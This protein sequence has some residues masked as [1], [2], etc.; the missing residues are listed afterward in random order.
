M[1]GGIHTAVEGVDPG[2]PGQATSTEG[3]HPPFFSSP[4]LTHSSSCLFLPS[5]SVAALCVSPLSFPYRWKTAFISQ[6]EA[7]RIIWEKCQKTPRGSNRQTSEDGLSEWPVCVCVYDSEREK[8]TGWRRPPRTVARGREKH[9]LSLSLACSLT[10]IQ[11][12]SLSLSLSILREW[13]IRLSGSLS[14]RAEAGI[15]KQCIMTV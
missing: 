10:P 12:S 7:K 9:S 8:T 14:P 6:V 2:Q 15:Q 13:L 11:P 4:Y 1:D 5:F 3:L